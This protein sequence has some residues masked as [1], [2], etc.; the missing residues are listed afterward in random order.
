MNIHQTLTVVGASIALLLLVLE[1]IRR[2][3]LREKYALAWI[4][5]SV[6]MASVPW[7][8]D[9]AVPVAKFL[10]ILDPRSFFFLLAILGLLL[11]SLQFSLALTTAFVHRRGLTQKMALLEQRIHALETQAAKAE[12]ESEKKTPSIPSSGTPGA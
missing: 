8:Y 2:N 4:F 6:S 9:L 1:L 10:G 5:I 3:M 12:S 7:L 11:L